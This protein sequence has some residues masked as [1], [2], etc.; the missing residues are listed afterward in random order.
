MFGTSDA[1]RL[2]DLFATRELEEIVWR[3][4][5]D[6][7]ANGADF[8]DVVLSSPKP[9][10]LQD[11]RKVGLTYWPD[12]PVARGVQNYAAGA[13]LTFARVPV[14]RG[15]TLALATS[16]PFGMGSLPVR[17][18]VVPAGSGA[19]VEGQ[20]RD[21]SPNPLESLFKGTGVVLGAVVVLALVYVFATLPK[22]AK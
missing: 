13:T 5:V 22:G 19:S 7:L 1:S 14:K 15:G 17:V 4:S 11:V 6:S 16:V 18:D 12:G 9:A 20:R 2:G 3:E 21:D 8:V 10:F